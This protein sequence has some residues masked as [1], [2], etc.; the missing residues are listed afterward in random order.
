MTEKQIR[1]IGQISIPDSQAGQVYSEGGYR[2]Q[3]ALAHTDTQSD[4][5]SQRYEL[6][7]KISYCLDANYWKGTTF[8]SFLSKHRRQLVI[9]TWTQK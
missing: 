4:T 5:S 7:D 6:T 8:E 3:S 1:K 9:E 2:Q